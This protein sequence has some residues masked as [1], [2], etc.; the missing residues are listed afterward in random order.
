VILSAE[1]LERGRAMY[2]AG[3]DYV[4]L[5]RLE[6]ARAFLDIL[7]AIERGDLDDPR[8]AALADLADREEVLA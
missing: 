1:M 8:Q 4:V 3:A 7:A 2:E 5:P 6:T